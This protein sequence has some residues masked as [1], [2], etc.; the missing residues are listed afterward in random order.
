MTPIVVF[1]QLLM[2]LSAHW[3][4][5]ERALKPMNTVYYWKEIRQISPIIRPLRSK[6]VFFYD[7]LSFLFFFFWFQKSDRVSDRNESGAKFSNYLARTSLCC[8]TLVAQLYSILVRRGK[9]RSDRVDKRPKVEPNSNFSSNCY[10]SLSDHD[11][12]K[13]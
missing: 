4:L 9:F 7:F 6:F 8:G 11:G 10:Y 5:N 3:R 2:A 1:L 13:S 12:W